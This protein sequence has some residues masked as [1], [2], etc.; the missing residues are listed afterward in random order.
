MLRCRT[1]LLKMG[2]E[3]KGYAGKTALEENGKKTVIG[4]LKSL[5]QGFLAA[6]AVNVAVPVILS[7]VAQPTHILT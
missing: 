4:S 5:A 1:R 3:T 2:F 7:R 6:A